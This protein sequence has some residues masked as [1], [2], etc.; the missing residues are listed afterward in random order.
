MFGFIVTILALENLSC[1]NES[2]SSEDYRADGVRIYSALPL[3]I[4]GDAFFS[5]S[6][7]IYLPTAIAAS[8]D[9]NP[10]RLPTYRSYAF[11]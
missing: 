11:G 8:S 7:A 5:D 10:L 4:D 1:R 2:L 9:F 6:W 3:A